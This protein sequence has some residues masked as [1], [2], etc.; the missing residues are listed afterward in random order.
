MSTSYSNTRLLNLLQPEFYRGDY[1]KTMKKL[2]YNTINTK[3]RIC[4]V[5]ARDE[6]KDIS[7]LTINKIK[8]TANRKL[9]RLSK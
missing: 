7:V 8:P 6:F 3:K 4:L 2:Q 9:N 1:D 5:T